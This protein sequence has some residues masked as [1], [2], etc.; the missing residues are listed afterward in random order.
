MAG[1]ASVNLKLGDKWGLIAGSRYESTFLNGD[2]DKN[3]ATAYQGEV[4]NDLLNI[5]DWRGNNV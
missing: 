3:A 1:Y 5:K 4:D 2:Y